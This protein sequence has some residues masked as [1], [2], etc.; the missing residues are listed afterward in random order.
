MSHPGESFFATFQQW[1]VEKLPPPTAAATDCSSI[2]NSFPGVLLKLSKMNF[3]C[4]RAL[5]NNT[6]LACSFSGA[7]FATGC[8]VVTETSTRNSVEKSAW[9]KFS[10]GGRYTLNWSG[11]LESELHNFREGASIWG[12]LNCSRVTAQVFPSNT[13][14]RNFSEWCLLVFS[15]CNIASPWWKTKGKVRPKKN[16]QSI[17]R[18]EKHPPN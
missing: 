15:E 14:V 13:L 5:V 12:A 7:T 17:K 9:G 8:W 3:W 4:Q 18:C 1:G 2:K 10:G 11:T 16:H 6:T